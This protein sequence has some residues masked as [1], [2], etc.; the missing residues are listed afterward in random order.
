MEFKNK[1]IILG[2]KINDLPLDSILNSIEQIF[3][4]DKQ[5]K[6]FTPNPEICL[7]ASKDEEYRNI[8]NSADFNI[9][10]GFGLKFGAVILGEK[11][12]N[13]VTGT[14]LSARLLE[15]CEKNGYSVYILRR[16]DSLAKAEDIN[17]LFKTKYP[18]I[19][20][21]IS[22]LNIRKFLDC[23][24][25]LND[26]N[27]FGPQ[28]LFVTLGVPAQE[29]WI[30]KFIKLVPSVK[31]ALAVGGAF[32]FF[33]GKMKR[34]P[35]MMREIGLE[36][37]YRFYLEP[38]RLM[39]I[40]HATADFFLACHAWKFRIMT[41]MRPNVLCVL[42]NREGK[43]LIQKNAHFE[44]HWQ[45]TQGGVNERESLEKSALR[46]IS[47]ELGIALKFLRLIKKI[48]EKNSY[49]WPR[50]AQLLRG[51]KGQEQTAL[52]FEFTGEDKDIH[53][54]KSAEVEEIKW[55]DK[56]ELAPLIHPHR[57]PFAEKI[58]KYLE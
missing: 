58:I 41:A 21:K 11:L 2:V 52:V 45:F 4:S 36:W 14:D 46:E 5:L 28:V 39:R 23:D 24:G 7:L 17:K 34:A 18:N 32:D 6:I 43:Y 30:N 57:R 13:R 53:I 19:K 35:K 3:Y 20:F 10:D 9:P 56:N 40:K 49:V 12:N 48:P 50:Y 42:R 27:D 29:I 37:L 31:A 8:L 44:N 51:Y 55:V 1:A 33:T 16:E 38:K 54:E 15:S 22:E 26:I 47:E 25:V